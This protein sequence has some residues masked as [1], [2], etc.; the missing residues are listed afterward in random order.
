MTISSTKP[1]QIKDVKVKKYSLR[2]REFVL[3]PPKPLILGP[4]LNYLPN[5]ESDIRRI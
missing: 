4:D 1:R 2:K 3:P 5:E